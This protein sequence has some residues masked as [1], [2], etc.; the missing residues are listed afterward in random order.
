MK[1]GVLHTIISTHAPLAGRDRHGQRGW[2]DR[3]QISTHAPLAGRD[4]GVVDVGVE[5]QISTHAPLAGRDRRPGRPAADAQHFNPRAPCGARRTCTFVASSRVL[6]QPTRPL[7]GATEGDGGKTLEIRGFQPTRPLRGAT[8][9]RR[10]EP[11][12]GGISTHAPLAGRDPSAR[13]V[14][15]RHWNFNPRAPCGARPR[16]TRSSATPSLFQPTRPLRGATGSGLG[17]QGRLTPISTHAPLA[18]RD[19]T[20]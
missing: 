10:P 9:H 19:R 2:Q 12:H 11:V 8:R 13:I 1:D 15:R 14:L 17:R 7:R 20:G 5:A 16:S 6:F 4:P 3:S 18:G